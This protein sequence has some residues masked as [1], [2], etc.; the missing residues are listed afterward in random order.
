VSLQK[1]ML[2]VFQKVQK[3]GAALAC[4]CSDVFSHAVSLQEK[5][6]RVFQKEPGL[7]DKLA[8]RRNWCDMKLQWWH[9]SRHEAA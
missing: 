7:G 6:L 8:G 2:R 9:I 5:R 1:K 4:S 3:V